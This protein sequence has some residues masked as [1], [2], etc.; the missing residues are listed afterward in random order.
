MEQAKIGELRG[1]VRTRTSIRKS[2]IYLR[3]R[4]PRGAAAGL[5]APSTWYVFSDELFVLDVAAASAS[6]AE[7][8]DPPAALASITS[9]PASIKSSFFG[10]IF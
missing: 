2:Y 7:P 6:T 8:A 10:K 4:P 1:D 3:P 9:A 5:A